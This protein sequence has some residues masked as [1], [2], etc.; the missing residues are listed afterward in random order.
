M[1]GRLSNGSCVPRSFNF[2]LTFYSAYDVSR[3]YF[4]NVVNISLHLFRSFK[5]YLRFIVYVLRVIIIWLRGNIKRASTDW[6][7]FTSTNYP[8]RTESSQRLG[9][10]IRWRPPLSK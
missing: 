5:H 9:K 1:N 4:A 3:F 8:F 2:D 6:R 10:S 7:T